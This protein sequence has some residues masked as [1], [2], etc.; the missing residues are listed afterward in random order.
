MFQQES[1][2]SDG[3]QVVSIATPNKYHYEMTKAAL[4]AGLHVICEKPLTFTVRE[5]EELKSIAEKNNRVVGITYGYAG[6]QMIHQA[7][8]MIEHGELGQIRIINMQFAHGWHSQPVEEI[9]PGTKWRVTPEIVG[10]S[11]VLGD[12]GT[13]TYYLAEQGKDKINE[14]YWYPDIN[15]GIVGVRLIE[16]CLESAAQGSIWIDF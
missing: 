2:R 3:I 5:A 11:Y 7:S 13:H 14:N 1:Q 9:D 12:V 8:N 16:R 15:A 10:P 4:E 6:H